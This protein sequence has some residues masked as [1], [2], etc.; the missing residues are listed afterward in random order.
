[1]GRFA[2]S[3]EGICD[4]AGNVWEWTWDRD[5]QSESVGTLRGGS[6]MYFRKECLLSSYR[7]ETPSTLRSPSI[8]FRCVFDD[9]RRNAA[10]LTKA[11]E[12]DR[13]KKG[14][15][16]AVVAAPK[17]SDEEIQRVREEMRK[18]SEPKP[19]AGPVVPDPATLKPAKAGEAH[20]NSLGMLLLPLEGAVP[21]LIGEHEV[22][23][24]DYEAGAKALGKPWDR[25]PTFAYTETHPIMNVTWKDAVQFLR[26]ADA[27]RTHRRT[28]RTT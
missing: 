20:T 3:P 25:R 10:F 27:K 14:E 4:L 6:W 1:M 24:Q 17:M 11:R 7:Y 18:K 23:V 12:A 15:S 16:P 21:A 9:K 22:R 8:G 19:V 13:G 5:S 28:D 26:V 2:P